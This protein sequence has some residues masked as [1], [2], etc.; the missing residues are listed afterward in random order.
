M[1]STWHII[2]YSANRHISHKARLRT[3]T[4]GWSALSKRSIAI[5]SIDSR[6]TRWHDGRGRKTWSRGNIHYVISGPTRYT[7][8]KSIDT[9]GRMPAGHQSWC[10]WGKS[11]RRRY[12]KNWRPLYHTSPSFSHGRY[13][14]RYSNYRYFRGVIYSGL[15]TIALRRV[16]CRFLS[17][18]LPR[19][20][21][22]FG[23]R[24]RVM[25][26]AQNTSLM[27]VNNLL[28]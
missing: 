19:F 20:L 17:P 25:S 23:R 11:A 24:K 13:S 21:I 8:R 6:Q 10:K 18:Y 12:R 4:L 2:D 9:C 5:S 7:S 28:E 27:S 26:S 22:L 14:Y 16:F 1:L 3:F 15:S